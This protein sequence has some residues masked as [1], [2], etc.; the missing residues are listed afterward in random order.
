MRTCTT[1]V[2][3]NTSDKFKNHWASLSAT[4]KTLDM[5]STGIFVLLRDFDIVEMLFVSIQKNSL[6]VI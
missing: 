3:F 6:V 1:L 4:K 5:A 2:G